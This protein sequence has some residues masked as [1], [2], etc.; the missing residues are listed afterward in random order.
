MYRAL[1][2]TQLKA[3]SLRQQIGALKVQREA[4]ASALTALSASSDIRTEAATDQLA[5]HW[6]DRAKLTRAIDAHPVWRTLLP[7]STVVLPR[8]PHDSVLSGPKSEQTRGCPPDQSKGTDGA[9]GGSGDAASGSGL[10]FRVVPPVLV[11][12]ELLGAAGMDPKAQRAPVFLGMP[13]LVAGILEENRTVAHLAAQPLVPLRFKPPGVF[14]A[15]QLLRAAHACRS[16]LAQ[17]QRARAREALAQRPRGASSGSSALSGPRSATPSTTTTT[18]PAA[19]APAA[20]ADTSPGSQPSDVAGAVALNT[21]SVCDMG[22]DG[23]GPGG[24]SAGAE[25]VGGQLRVVLSVCARAG[26]LADHAGVAGFHPLARRL[27]LR[28]AAPL[29]GPGGRVG[30]SAC[31]PV[32]AFGAAWGVLDG[33]CSGEPTLSPGEIQ[34]IAQVF[35]RT[36]VAER[37]SGGGLKEGAEAARWP[38]VGELDWHV[39]RLVTG[40]DYGFR[41]A[42]RNLACARLRLDQYASCVHR[43]PLGE[44]RPP[45][46]RTPAAAPGVAET[47]WAFAVVA[48]AVEAIVRSRY[49]VETAYLS[50][51]SAERQIRTQRY[52]AALRARRRKEIRAQLMEYYGLSSGVSGG[53]TGDGAGGGG[54]GGDVTSTAVRRTR[55]CG[56]A[57]CGSRLG[58]HSWP[59]P[60][61][62][63]RVHPP[64][65]VPG[66]AGPPPSDPTDG[67]GVGGAEMGGSAA[68]TAATTPALLSAAPTSGAPS[69]PPVGSSGEGP[70]PHG[71]TP[72][73]A[74]AAAPDALAS[75]PWPDRPHS[76]A[77]AIYAGDISD[78]DDDDDGN[79]DGGDADYGDDS[80]LGEVSAKAKARV[81]AKAR[82][83]AAR[84]RGRSPLHA[85]RTGSSPTGFPTA[86]SPDVMGANVGGMDPTALEAVVSA[87]EAELAAQDAQYS[88]PAVVRE[89]RARRA[90]PEPQRI[91]PRLRGLGVLGDR[92]AWV[93]RAPLATWAAARRTNPWSVSE[94]RRFIE[95][96]CQFPGDFARIS[97]GLPFK[98]C[99]ECV[100]F[101]YRYK[102]QLRLRPRAYHYAQT[103]AKIPAPIHHAALQQPY[104]PSASMLQPHDHELARLQPTTPAL[105]PATHLTVDPHTQLYSQGWRAAPPRYGTDG[106]AGPPHIHS[107]H[108][109]LHLGSGSDPDPASVGAGVDGRVGSRGSLGGD[110]ARAAAAH[111]YG[112]P[113]GP[114]HLLHSPLRMLRALAA[115]QVLTHSP[116]GN[117]VANQ[118]PAAARGGALAGAGAATGAAPAHL[119]EI[120]RA[121]LPDIRGFAASGALHLLDPATFLP[122]PSDP[123]G[124][125]YSAVSAAVAATADRARLTAVPYPPDRAGPARLQPSSASPTVPPRGSALSIGRGL[126]GRTAAEPATQARVGAP[127]PKPEPS[128]GPGPL[129]GPRHDGSADSAGR[130]PVT[131]LDRHTGGDHTPRE[132]PSALDIFA[133]YAAVLGYDPPAPVGPPAMSAVLERSDSDVDINPMDLMAAHAEIHGRTVE[134]LPPNLEALPFDPAAEKPEDPEAIPTAFPAA[135]TPQPAALPPPADPFGQA[136][137]HPKPKPP[138]RSMHPPGYEHF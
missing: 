95:L 83:R 28:S 61:P 129:P 87:R 4:L 49:A 121:I 111:G 7:H 135:P 40:P 17:A 126:V 106:S 132:P 69:G 32:A 59:H 13:A 23:V 44:A 77:G 29:P 55:R 15:F 131:G 45:Q 5:R 107:H 50:R 93:I 110:L 25:T 91:V 43:D 84:A 65:P 26:F 96:Y 86:A 127:T 92:A 82:A 130:E 98:S 57:S 37:S 31:D 89:W 2:E 42:A 99:R 51:L 73:S 133:R 79:D 120:P 109:D 136:Q 71:R 66:Q 67:A 138:L 119:Q 74:G 128:S 85:H 20:S 58:S 34:L 78:D 108:P 80:D 134:A 46:Y 104:P 75:R 36:A 54:S 47:R 105:A 8:A 123:L 38:A 21:G 125:R 35:S 39:R 114:G 115:S 41:F 10:P 62:Q 81:K 102:L 101:Y 9:V 22:V 103:C 56:G 60:G 94:V 12:G 88:H 63:A 27:H 137:P 124:P 100:A 68:P 116:A 6:A 3:K 30:G 113:S 76:M 1:Q 18:T 16:T 24:G 52:T 90:S 11:T 97:A 14:A 122:A 117:L 118:A 112:D 48:P 72:V 64:S 33:R 53:A 70:R 19:G